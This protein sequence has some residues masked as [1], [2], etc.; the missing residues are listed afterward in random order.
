M[1][2]SGLLDFSSKDFGTPGRSRRQVRRARLTTAFLVLVLAAVALFW[3]W[4]HLRRQHETDLAAFRDLRS[5]FT[6]VDRNVTPLLHGDAEPCEESD[7]H[8]ILTRTYSPEA[9]PTPEEVG[10]ALRL[11]GFWPVAKS[12]GALFTFE[13]VVDD[14]LI[15][16]DVMGT[17]PDARGG[18]LRATSSASALACRFFG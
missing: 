6:L 1:T 14:H 2:D 9:G 17:D 12:P 3:A 11:V 7:D 15:T 16:V 8:G 5:R 13:R 10:D 4:L 18:S